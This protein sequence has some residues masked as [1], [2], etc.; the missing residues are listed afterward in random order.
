MSEPEL[1]ETRFGGA[2]GFID[3][4]TLLAI[5]LTGA[6]P[7]RQ[8]EQVRR[9]RQAP[10]KV[11][12]ELLAAE[13]KGNYMRSCAIG[14]YEDYRLRRRQVGKHAEPGAAADGGGTTVLVV[15]SS[16]SPRRC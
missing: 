5:I 12:R 9:Y 11:D 8:R 2:T 13:S 15:H 10:R 3:N 14:V 4:I 6:A 16:L 7:I 1:N